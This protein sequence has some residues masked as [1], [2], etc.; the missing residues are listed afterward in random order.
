MLGS[1]VTTELEDKIQT[2]K[3]QKFTGFV[4]ISGQAGYQWYVYCLLG[5]IVWTRSR[6]HPLRQWQRYLAFHSPIFFEQVTQSVQ[7]AYSNWNYAT[8]ARLVKLKKFRRDQFYRIAEGCIIEDLFDI[9]QSGTLQQQAGYSLTYHTYEKEAAS[10]PFIMLE[11]DIAWSEAKDVWQAWQQ[12]ELTEISPDYAP[13]IIQLDLL[14]EHAPAQSFQVLESFV[15]GETT[16]RELAFKFKQ[17][18]LVLTK[19][20]FPYISREMLSFVELPDI[21]KD[22]DEGFH[23]ELVEVEAPEAE[24]MVSQADAKNGQELESKSSSGQKQ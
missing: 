4:K 21:V 1:I 20:I 9:I 6:S 3:E 17:P 5:R 14:K 15:D 23:P 10:M 2:Y 22:A 7:S 13:K 18:V 11:K 24:Q 12:A 8:L 16:L 19:S